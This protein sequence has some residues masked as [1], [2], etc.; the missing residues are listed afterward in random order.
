[1]KTIT[2]H[3]LCYFIN[4]RIKM[5]LSKNIQLISIRTGVNEIN[6]L[7]N[8]NFKYIYKNIECT[9]SKQYKLNVNN[10]EKNITKIINDFDKIMK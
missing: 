10:L 6:T 9:F 3:E 8:V 4:F 2:H 5:S 7:F 1:M